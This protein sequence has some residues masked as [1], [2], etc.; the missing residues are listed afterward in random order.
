MAQITPEDEIVYTLEDRPG[1]D[2]E[3]YDDQQ[4]SSL[5]PWVVLVLGAAVLAGLAAIVIL[6][7]TGRIG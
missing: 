2:F 6:A 5:I 3:T 4:H 1:T 7:V